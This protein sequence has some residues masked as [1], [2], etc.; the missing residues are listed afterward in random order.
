MTKEQAIRELNRIYMMLS[1][2][3]KKALDMAIKA[4]EQEP[5]TGHWITHEESITLLTGR[6]ASGGVICSECGYKTH[7]RAHVVV[8]CPYRFC[9][10]C[11]T[12]MVEPQES[13]VNNE[14]G[15]TTR[16]V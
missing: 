12:E 4:L 11:G 13:E 5:K 3:M 14:V 6:T 1:E 10:G 7:N 2:D 8:G 15:N 16:N 9:P